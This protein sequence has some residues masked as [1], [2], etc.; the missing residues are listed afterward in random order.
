MRSTVVT[1]FVLSATLGCTQEWCVP[2][3]AWRVGEFVFQSE[4]YRDITCIG[5]TVI[6]GY[7]GYRMHSYNVGFNG[8]IE[9]NNESTFTTVL[10]QD[11]MWYLNSGILD[12]LVWFGAQVGDHWK[13]GPTLGGGQDTLRANVVAAG[14]RSFGAVPLR[15]VVVDYSGGI[16]E[17]G[18]DTIYE[19][20]GPLLSGWGNPVSC[21][22]S[23]ESTCPKLLCYS[24]N[25]IEWV[26]PSWTGL[27][28]SAPLALH[29]Q[30]TSELFQ[31]QVTR[32][33]KNGVA[34][35]GYP[36]SIGG[37]RW[38]FLDALGRKMSNG[39]IRPQSGHT[40]IPMDGFP[41][42]VYLLLVESLD[43]G[44]SVRFLH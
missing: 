21:Y 34:L 5:D 42:G 25:E 35:L 10:D 44:S 16:W 41:S 22:G 20:L 37:G 29:S 36:H 33:G 15:Y 26:N 40:I 19:R 17:P 38:T 27:Q 12:T 9:I 7:Q 18:T 31:L 3:A 14:T 6:D 28:C 30:T 4:L 39:V 23:M 11:I 1:C 13:F 8:P 24:D 43:G 32:S 2:G